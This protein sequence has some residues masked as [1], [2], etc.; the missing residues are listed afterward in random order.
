MTN[1]TIVL[2]TAATLA[3]CA[4]ATSTPVS[5]VQSAHPICMFRGAAPAGMNFKVLGT[6]EGSKEF[7][8]SVNE[9]LPLMAD[10]ARKLGA[11]AVVNLE[12]HQR[13]GLWAW[14]HPVGTGIAVKIENRPEFN[15][16]ALGGLLQ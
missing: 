3:G 5:Q 8:G 11:D 6:I 16:L 15:C 4:T 9:I 1:R 7:Y 13:V 10:E 12:T 2:L 14:A